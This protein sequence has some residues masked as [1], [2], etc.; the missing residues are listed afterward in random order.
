MPSWPG[1]LSTV[2][3]SSPA[4]QRR[5]CMPRPRPRAK[6]STRPTPGSWQR[7]AMPP[8]SCAEEIEPP[9]SPPA[10]SRRPYPSSPDR[11]TRTRSLTDAPPAKGHFVSD[12]RSQ[13]VRCVRS[14][15]KV[16]LGRLPTLE[17]TPQ[18]RGKGSIEATFFYTPL[19]LIRR[20]GATHRTGASDLFLIAQRLCDRR[21]PGARGAGLKNTLALYSILANR[22]CCSAV[23]KRSFLVRWSSGV[24][25][26][27]FPIMTFVIAH[28]PRAL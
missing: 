21:K 3:K 23:G 6:R 10:A 9:P 2:P 12:A 27:R 20:I 18:E 1:I 28:P 24:G 17:L 15:L 22:F 19:A 7:S 8:R 13:G 11:Q 25:R 16:G 4:R 5:G 26:S 14:F